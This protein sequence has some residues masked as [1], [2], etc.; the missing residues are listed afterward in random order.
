MN[1]I[2]NA[3]GVC[4]LD[5]NGVPCGYALVQHPEFDSEPY[6]DELNAACATSNDQSCTTNC[7]DSI[8]DAKSDRGCCLNTLFYNS[9]DSAS[10]P[11]GL[12]YSI[13]KSCGIET[14]GVCD[15][16]LNIRSGAT[17]D[18]PATTAAAAPIIE[19]KSFTIF[20][21]AVAAGL[22]SLFM[23]ITV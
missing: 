20:I 22:M 9:L 13:W 21:T 3:I 8:V 12:S 5:A 7:R 10:L 16:L 4:S 1:E 18:P 14:P 17:D 6:I 11:P 19:K 15:S 23:L 2:E